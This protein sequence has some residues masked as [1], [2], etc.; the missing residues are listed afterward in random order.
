MP[1]ALGPFTSRKA[2]CTPRQV[3]HTFRAMS[4]LSRYRELMQTLDPSGDPRAAFESGW[5]VDRWT[6]LAAMANVARR[7]ELEPW[8][9]HLLVGG[10]GSGKTTELW[11]IHEHLVTSADQIG[12]ECEYIDMGEERPLSSIQSCDLVFAATKRILE[13]EDERRSLRRRA[14]SRKRVQSF[15]RSRAGMRRMTPIERMPQHA[16]RRT[17][18]R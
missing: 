7:L 6:H 13:L 1:R 2:L 15:V 11:R 14:R 5:C 9:S 8:S 17:L 10:I 3:P 16:L 18:Q 12:A 4:R